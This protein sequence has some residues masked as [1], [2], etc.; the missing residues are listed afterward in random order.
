[1]VD[2]LRLTT[3]GIYAGVAYC[4]IVIAMC[5]FL[6]VNPE[7]FFRFLNFGRPLPK[8]IENLWIQAAYR[9]FAVAIVL[10]AVWFLVQIIRP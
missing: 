6:A 2:N 5:V 9:I 4:C 1:M 3:S 10:N 7:R 8:L